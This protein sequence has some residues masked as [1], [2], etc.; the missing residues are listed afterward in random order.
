VSIAHTARFP[1]SELLHWAG[2]YLLGSVAIGG[3]AFSFSLSPAHARNP[4]RGSAADAWGSGPVI[5]S[6]IEAARHERPI[7]GVMPGPTRTGTARP[8]LLT[9]PLPRPA[10]V[11]ASD[12]VAAAPDTTSNLPLMPAAYSPSLHP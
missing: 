8:K 9:L 2:R 3:L 1:A 10:T 6:L 5:L 11:E 12:L 7:A 4:D